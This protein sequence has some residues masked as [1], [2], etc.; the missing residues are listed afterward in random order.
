MDIAGY[1]HMTFDLYQSHRYQG[2]KCK[3]S[4]SLTEECIKAG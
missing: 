3:I 4:L 1:G 2:Q